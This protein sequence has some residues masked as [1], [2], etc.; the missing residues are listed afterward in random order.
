MFQP[1]RIQSRIRTNADHKEQ[2]RLED[3]MKEAENQTQE[4]NKIQQKR[5]HEVYSPEGRPALASQ[6]DIMWNGH[7]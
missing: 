6:S 2:A 1:I 3:R 5:Q 7:C 4:N